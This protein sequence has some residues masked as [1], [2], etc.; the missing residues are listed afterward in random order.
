M[1]RDLAAFLVQRQRRVDAALDRYLIAPDRC[2]KELISAMRYSALAPG[3]R[4]RPMLVIAGAEAVGGRAEEVLPTACAVEL[5]H[6]FSLVHDDLPAIDNDNLRRGQPTAHVEFGEAMAILAGDGLLV[7]GFEL[8]G[9]NAD[10]AAPDAVC[11]AF[12]LI[13]RAS[14]TDGMVAG[15][16]VDILSEGKPPDAERLEYIHEYKTAALIRA[17][18]V[19]GAILAGANE[20]EIATLSQYGTFVGTA[21]QIADD[22]LNQT[23]DTAQLG[24][25]VGSDIERG[26]LTY[27]A[28]YGL[29]KSREMAN[30]LVERAVTALAPLGERAEPLRWLAEY[31]TDRSA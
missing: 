24:K 27:P 7:M 13:A 8:I 11:R 1:R 18:V 4:L 2:P 31:S 29:A 21:F 14:G 30:K 12:T 23:G 25:A 19:A 26:K 9:Q 5:I 15:Q 6:A 28:L 3:K 20:T 16:V 22:I 10:T 17:S